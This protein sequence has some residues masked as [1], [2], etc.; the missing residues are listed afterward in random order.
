MVLARRLGDGMGMECFVVRD[1]PGFATSRLG[2][3]LGLEAIRMLEQEVASA[4]DIDR[5]IDG[6]R[7]FFEGSSRAPTAR[8]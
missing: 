7:S 5:V 2:V 3:V 6:V 8:G 4:E 1:A